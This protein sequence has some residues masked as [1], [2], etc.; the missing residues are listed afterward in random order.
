[1][2]ELAVLD[3]AG[4]TVD[5]GGAV[6]RVLG[7]VAAAH[8]A[9]DPDVHPWMGAD[10][11]EALAAL[12][13]VGRDDPRAAAAHATFVT[14]LV[15]AYAAAPPK[16]LPGAPE[17]LVA[18]RAAGVRVALTT[19]FDRQVTEPL[20]AAVGWDVPG[21]LDAVVCADEVGAGRP[22]PDMIRAAMERLAVTDPARVLVA[23]DTVLDV[24]AGRAAGAG[25]VIGV[26]TGAQGTEELSAAA[27]TQVL[28]GVAELPGFLGLARTP[29]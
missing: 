12:L 29:N 5:E 21:T 17:A 1:M 6:Y 13:G 25:L 11:R 28:G 20:L 23:G 24:R 7:A 18:L 3:I 26:L 22:A 8:G 15:A 14:E 2:I 16:P 9:T 27:P 10:K 19:G 4:T